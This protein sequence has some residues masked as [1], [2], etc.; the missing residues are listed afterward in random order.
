MAK[1]TL[2]CM[3]CHGPDAM[4]ARVLRFEED[5]GGFFS[6]VASLRLVIARPGSA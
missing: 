5:G 1:K 6:A 3:R 4:L 2:H